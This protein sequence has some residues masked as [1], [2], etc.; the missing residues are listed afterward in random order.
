MKKCLFLLLMVFGAVQGSAQDDDVPWNL[1]QETD[2]PTVKAVSATCQDLAPKGFKV[3]S[4]VDGDLNGDR[5]ADCVLVLQ[6]TDK[7]FLYENEGL[8]SSEFDTNPRILAIAFGN[9]GGGYTL[10][11]QSNTLIVLPNAPNMTEPFQ[12]AKI[13]KGVLHILIEE[14]YSA[15]SWSMSNR[16]Y[17]F[18]FQN[19]EFVLI[20]LD[21]NHIRRNTGEISSR[22]YNFSTG[23]AIRSE[24][25]VDDDGKGK[26]TQY[27]FKLDKLK[28]LK[29]VPAPFT[30]EIE[31]GVLI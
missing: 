19:G 8:G 20:G 31:E 18:R 25:A 2:H 15:G 5:L 10:K 29:T 6:G 13:E 17:K 9:K 23:K 28:T 22:S 21:Y 26:E 7:K 4:K 30:W 14:F 3:V 24:G 1:P 16:T 27:K 12:E 11:E